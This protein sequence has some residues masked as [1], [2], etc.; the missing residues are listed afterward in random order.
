MLLVQSREQ[1]HLAEMLM[2]FMHN[3]LQLNFSKCDCSCKLCN[4]CKCELSVAH[5]I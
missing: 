5:L 4:T 2:I 1:C 3:S